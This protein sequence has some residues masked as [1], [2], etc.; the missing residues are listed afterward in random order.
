MKITINQYAQTLFDLTNGKG[1]AEVQKVVL[2]FFKVVKKNGQL[3]LMSK[4]MEAFS[5]IWNEKNKIIEAEIVTACELDLETKSKLEDQLK[6]KY[7]V[8]NVIIKEKLDKSVLGGM[9]LRI[10]DEVFDYS[11]KGQLKKLKQELAK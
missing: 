6:K 4:V 7:G 5:L 11:I 10:K 2:N 1:E 3:K 8:E 9:V